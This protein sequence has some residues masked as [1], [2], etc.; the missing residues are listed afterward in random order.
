MNYATPTLLRGETYLCLLFGSHPTADD[1][2]A[3]GAHR[4]EV[5]FKVVKEH[6]QGGA[7]HHEPVVPL[8]LGLL[9][10]D[11]EGELRVMQNPGVHYYRIK[12]YIRSDQHALR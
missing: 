4:V 1:G 7:V 5:V 9:P 10:D 8:S 3:P 6:L 2:D 11:D 12:D